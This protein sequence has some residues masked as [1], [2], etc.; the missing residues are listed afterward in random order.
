MDRAGCA[1]CYCND[2][3]YPELLRQAG[4][5][6]VDVLFAP[7]R[8]LVPFVSPDAAEANCLAI[9]DGSRWYVRQRTRRRC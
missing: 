4:Q 7:T 3:G 5:D 6:R 9:D 8:D 1:G 2:M